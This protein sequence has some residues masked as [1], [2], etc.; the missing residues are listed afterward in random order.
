MINLFNTP[1]V[2]I[3]N[4]YSSALAIRTTVLPIIPLIGTTVVR[5]PMHSASWFVEVKKSLWIYELGEI[6]DL[7]CSPVPKLH[8]KRTVF[9]KVSQ[10]YKQNLID[11]AV[12]YKTLKYLNKQDFTP[13]K[14]HPVL[15]IPL[16]SVRE[17]TR[18]PVK[19]KLLTGSY[20]FQSTRA[21]FNQND[22]DPTCLLCGVESED[23]IYHTSSSVVIY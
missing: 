21:A 5:I 23:P 14:I 15:R 18:V 9:N 2:P 4:T 22:I 16:V 1:V 3:T 19:V 11:I 17:I 20:L 10:K 12:L 6:E 8:W 13:G 7:L